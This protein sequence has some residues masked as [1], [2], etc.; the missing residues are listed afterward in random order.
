MCFRNQSSVCPPH[1]G[2]EGLAGQPSF[3]SFSS[4]SVFLLAPGHWW[5]LEMVHQSELGKSGVLVLKLHLDNIFA[6]VVEASLATERKK[7]ACRRQRKRKWEEKM[8]WWMH[9][10]RGSG[11]LSQSRDV[12]RVWILTSAGKTIERRNNGT[13]AGV[14]QTGAIHCLF[15]A[16]W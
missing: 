2:L 14:H 13:A 10:R 3:S 15:R 12:C 8:G 1:P 11:D 16:L 6:L 7:L 9:L 4:F 5:A